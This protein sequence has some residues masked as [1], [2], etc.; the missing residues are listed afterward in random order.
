MI[1]FDPSLISHRIV[2]VKQI[3]T[4]LG[5][6]LTYLENP[7]HDKSETKRMA[8]PVVVARNLIKS[9]SGMTRF[10]K[11]LPVNVTYYGNSVV[12]IEKHPHSSFGIN[13]EKENFIEEWQPRSTL[14]MELFLLKPYKQYTSWYTDG[15]FVYAFKSSTLEQDVREGTFITEDGKFR[16]I[17]CV[18]IDLHTLYRTNMNENNMLHG[19][20]TIAYVASNNVF[21]ISPPVWKD[22]RSS[23]TSAMKSGL[24]ANVTRENV[25]VE[26]DRIDDLMMLFL[27][28]T[29]AKEQA[30]EEKQK[31]AN[32]WFTDMINEANVNLAFGLYAAGSLAKHIG[33]EEV[34]D[35]FQLP[36]LMVD[37]RT[38]NLFKLKD[39][40]K[41][42]YPLSMNLEQVMAWLLGKL[43]KAENSLEYFQA[44]GRTIKYLTRRGIY[45][46]NSLN[47]LLKTQDETFE[48]PTLKLDPV[49]IG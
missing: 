26:S 41:Q 23:I 43:L 20:E 7:E 34:L 9:A 15:R 49:D 8:I 17:P 32:P 47:G 4:A 5:G 45:E 28:T 12:S 21:S 46:R 44:V 29:D 25:D 22:A 24:F 48:L 31:K 38:V 13:M 1:V 35:V 42:T 3:T 11:P 33:T 36:E 37:L 27:G 16:L 14:A 6:S 39:E 19:R 40:T 30:I 18:A 2:F 10:L